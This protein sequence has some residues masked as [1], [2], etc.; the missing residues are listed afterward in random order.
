MQKKKIP[1]PLI[2]SIAV[3]AVI[4]ILAAS[5]LNGGIGGGKQMNLNTYFGLSEN[6]EGAI[7]LNGEV[8][9]EK[10]LVENGSLY[11]DYYTVWDKLNSGFCWS[12]DEQVLCL[13][14]Q[15][16]SYEWTPTDGTDDL[17]LGEDGSLYLNTSLIS[18]CSDLELETF[19]DPAR[20]VIRTEWDGV[21]KGSILQDVDLHYKAGS[22]SDI[23]AELSAGDEVAI[24]GG[25]EGWQY[26]TTRDGMTGYVKDDV[27][28]DAGYLEH[29]SDERFTYSHVMMQ[30]QI[31]MVWHYI[32][33]LE[34]N[35]YLGDMIA[36]V[37][38]VNVI[39]PTWFNLADA[40]GNLISY[41]DASY[42]ELAH[43]NGMQVWGMIGDVNGGDVDTGEALATSSV[44]ANIIMQ[45]MQV[46]SSVGLDGINVDFETITEDTAPLYIEF[47][48]E[49][50]IAAHAQGLVVSTD[51]YV[52]T[53]TQFYKRAELAKSVDYLVIMGYDE[54]TYGS[55]E[56]GSV[57]SLPFVEQGIVDTLSEAP[58][59]QVIN[60][61]PFYTR[62]WTETYGSEALESEAF[63]MDGADAFVEEH[64][65]TLSWDGSAGQYTGSAE[66][67]NHLYSIWMEDE[68]AIREKAA[69]IQQY[70]L[71]GIAAWRLGL[72]RSSAWSAILETL[73]G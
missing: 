57:A 10:A 46:A 67:G 35:A 9:E 55:S 62:G 52:P 48:K 6:S 41:A 73:N 60:A 45:I 24:L 28:E 42:V 30:D 2:I 19:E 5:A 18:S 33:S 15:N 43:A 64:G 4:I 16:E 56:A 20:V 36:E 7:V 13:T 14:L 40:D 8:L 53:Y 17:L 50:C 23:L 22:R 3:V 27:V 44:R 47:M 37:N 63:G 49:L 69:L 72:E 68:S 1:I 31:V 29:V 58:A 65:I 21:Q 59:E 12:E 66:D 39:S 34:N 26:I 71:A 11:I 51:N 61:I 38:G 54:H 25:E 32:D 70:G